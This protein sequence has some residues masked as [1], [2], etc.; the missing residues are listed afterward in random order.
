[1][2]TQPVASIQNCYEVYQDFYNKMHDN[3]SILAPLHFHKSLSS[4]E[5][6]DNLYD[7]EFHIIVLDDLMEKNC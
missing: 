7:G 6:I 4:Q 1:M 3:P 5:D 2:L